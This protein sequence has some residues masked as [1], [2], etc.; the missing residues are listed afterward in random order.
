NDYGYG[1]YYS[2]WEW[3]SMNRNNKEE[4][5]SDLRVDA[6][7][8]NNRLFVR[9]S[10]KDLEQ[11]RDFLAKIGEST[12]NQPRAERV[13]VLESLDPETTIKV[14]ER[15]RSTWPAVGDN[16]LIIRGPGGTAPAAEPPAKPPAEAKEADRA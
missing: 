16:P 3:E 12:D 10:D 11:V 15:L 8:E 14:L 1:Y 7:V 9:G 2:P 6:D 5:A 4:R 13:R